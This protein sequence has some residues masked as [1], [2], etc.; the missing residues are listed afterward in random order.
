MVGNRR[1][2]GGA[3]LLWKPSQLKINSPRGCTVQQIKQHPKE[4]LNQL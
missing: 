3:V 2:R 1:E 4:T